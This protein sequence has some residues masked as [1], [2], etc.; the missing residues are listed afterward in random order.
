MHN[1]SIIPDLLGRD[2]NICSADLDKA[3][4]LNF[5][6][7]QTF[8]DD[9][10]LLPSFANRA[11]DNFINDVS[12]TI[13]KV[14]KGL[15]K[16]NFNCAADPDRIPCTFY[17]WISS[18]LSFPLCKIFRSSMLNDDIPEAWFLTNVCLIFKN[19]NKMILQIIAPFH[20]HA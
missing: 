1:R 9:N 15:S 7:G 8:I 5:H 11:G 16:V 12:F 13:S 20:L 6:F 4:A 17:R 18:C 19:G 14:K 3:N 2:G 10:R